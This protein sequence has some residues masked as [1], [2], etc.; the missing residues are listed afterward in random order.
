MT[1]PEQTTFFINVIVQILDVLAFF[2]P[3]PKALILLIG[4]NRLSIIAG[5][6]R[7]AIIFL[8]DISARHVFGLGTDIRPSL[9]SVIGIKSETINQSIYRRANRQY[10]K[11]TFYLSVATILYKDEEPDV[12]EKGIRDLIRDF[13]PP[14]LPSNPLYEEFLFKSYTSPKAFG[15][16]LGEILREHGT[17]QQYLSSIRKSFIAALYF[18]SLAFISAFTAARNWTTIQSIIPLPVL[19]FLPAIFT[20]LMLFPFMAIGYYIYNVAQAIQKHPAKKKRTIKDDIPLI[21][22]KKP[23]PRNPTLLNDIP[24]FFFEHFEVNIKN[25]ARLYIRITTPSFNAL[26]R[27]RYV[28]RKRLSLRNPL[29]IS[30]CAI[31]TMFSFNEPYITK[32]VLCMFGI[33]FLLYYTPAMI[34]YLFALIVTPL[35][36]MA[37]IAI[38]VARKPNLP[39]ILVISAVIF[40][41]VARALSM[42]G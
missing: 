5:A 31:A 41:L 35:G 21:T 26:Y 39:D 37:K 8:T 1:N 17:I 24:D 11:F 16:I 2:L 34:T 18:L 42:M 7:K 30:I 15:Q 22:K 36:L 23:L 32:M 33:F 6:I 12:R 3:Q 20:I 40:F 4:Q 28:E 38:D 25:P 9:V 29:I 14:L 13:W 10:S 27:N 19:Y